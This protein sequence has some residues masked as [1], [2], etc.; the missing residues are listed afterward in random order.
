MNQRKTGSSKGN[1]NG[2]AYKRNARRALT[3]SGTASEIDI[4][5]SKP[6]QE[7]VMDG[8]RLAWRGVTMAE[9]A[10]ALAKRNV[11]AELGEV[12]RNC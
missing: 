3:K 9:V 6:D 5:R 4:R 11:A 8:Q 10:V 2:I 7:R 12:P 1:A